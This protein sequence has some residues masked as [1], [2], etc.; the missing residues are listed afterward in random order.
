MV[1]LAA[2][3]SLNR[4]RGWKRPAGIAAA[5]PQSSIAD[6]SAVSPLSK[7]GKNS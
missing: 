4:T 2:R 3:A 6:W 5:A 1:H 7:Q